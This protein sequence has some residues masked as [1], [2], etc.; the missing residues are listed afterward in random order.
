V[1]ALRALDGRDE[2]V[3]TFVLSHPESKEL[4]RRLEDFLKFVLPRYEREGKAYLTVA[5][6]CTGGRHRSVTVAEELKRS[7][8]G[9]GYAPTV[10]HRDLQR[11]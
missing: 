3:R 1:D 9:V 6:G 2:R 10:V 11:E 7:L 4:L 8:A 5:I